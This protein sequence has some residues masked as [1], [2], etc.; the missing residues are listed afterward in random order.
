MLVASSPGL[1]TRLHG[2]WQRLAGSLLEAKVTAPLSAVL[3]AFGDFSGMQTLGVPGLPL[4]HG[5]AGEAAATAVASAPGS[6]YS[7]VRAGAAGPGAA[8]LVH[9]LEVHGQELAD[10]L[11]EVGERATRAHA[12]WPRVVVIVNNRGRARFSLSALALA[13]CHVVLFP[14][15]CS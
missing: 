8:A 4:R 7:L 5:D 1:A 15:L 10:G 3:R 9:A 14:S 13:H 6:P 2:D 12:R 11:A